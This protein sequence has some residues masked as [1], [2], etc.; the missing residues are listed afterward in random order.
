VKTLRF[1]EI[2]ILAPDTA[3]GLFLYAIILRSFPGQWRGRFGMQKPGVATDGFAYSSS[4]R[5]AGPSQYF[6]GGG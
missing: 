1:L 5:L 3:S 2:E 6:G 4:P